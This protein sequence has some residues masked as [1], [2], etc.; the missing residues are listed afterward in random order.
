M[1]LLARLGLRHFVI[2]HRLLTRSRRAKISYRATMPHQ[3]DT[4]ESVRTESIICSMK[5]RPK[6]GTRFHFGNNDGFCPGIY[7]AKL[8]RC[9]NVKNQ[10]TTLISGIS[11]KMRLASPL[12]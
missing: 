8:V 12:I 1:M 9:P 6:G 7:A 4:H 5:V 2:Y 3:S 10:V 11:G